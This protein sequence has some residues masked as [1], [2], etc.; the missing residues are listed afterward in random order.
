MQDQV[1]KS[2]IVKGQI[3]TIFDLWSNF[4][5]FPNFMEPVVSVEHTGENNTHW[6]VDGPFGTTIEWNAETTRLEKHKRIAWNSLD[7]DI[8][9][10]G[11]VTFTEL[12]QNETQVTVTV[13][14]I[15]GESLAE[16]IF[17]QL[18]G[19]TEKLATESL[20]KFKSFAEEKDDT[21]N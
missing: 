10:S 21:K 4:E 14:Y 1:T 16:P 20:R 8:K 7:G 17:N 9:T 12:P 15:P 19:N 5:N 13:K 3:E 18:F 2:I 11:Q 6:K